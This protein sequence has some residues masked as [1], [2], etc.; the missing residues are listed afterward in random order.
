MIKLIL[1][2]MILTSVLSYVVFADEPAPSIIENNATAHQN[3]IQQFFLQSHPDKISRA[4]ASYYNNTDKTVIE[5]LYG[6]WQINIATPQPRI[7]TLQV[8]TNFVDK[9]FGYYGW[10]TKNSVGCYFEP[11]MLGSLYS[12]LCLYTDKTANISH[13]WL[14]NISG[15]S[16]TG[17]YHAGTTEDFILKL[18][19]NQLTNISGIN[20]LKTNE[21]YYNDANGELTI[22]KVSVS[23][24]SYSVIMK[25]ENNGLFSVKNANP[26]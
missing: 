9:N 1:K 14:F 19:A 5:A 26:L 18:N 10:D 16:L 25:R 17:K 15:T 3:S 7:D 4:A 11:K 13:R 23:G 2:S 8:D 12:Y 6:T 21:P 24:K 20:G 22:P